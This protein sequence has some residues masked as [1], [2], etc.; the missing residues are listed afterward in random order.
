MTR[1]QGACLCGAV[2]VS[3][4][5]ADGVTACHCR[6]CQTWTGGSPLF[7]VPA[8]GEVEI[9]GIGATASY[10]A[11]AWGERVFC[12][13]CGTTLWW[14][15]QG[16]PVTSVAPGLF[17]GQDG[18]AVSEEIFVDCRAGWMPRWPDASQSTEAEEMAKLDAYL[19]RQGG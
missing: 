1:R 12:A 15:M 7:T 16:K 11:S 17:A 3:G 4:E 10:M 19:Q 9:T 2:T 6:Q 18:L 5:F 8:Q 14:K 13:T